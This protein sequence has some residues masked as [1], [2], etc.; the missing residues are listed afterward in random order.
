MIPQLIAH[1][2]KI[3]LIETQNYEKINE[4]TNHEV[5]T[6]WELILKVDTNKFPLYKEY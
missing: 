3:W 1:L 4:S 5:Y 6:I 2:H